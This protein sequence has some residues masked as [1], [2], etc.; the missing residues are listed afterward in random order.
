MN[1]TKTIN[2]LINELPNDN[3]TLYQ[4]EN[5]MTH[6][7]IDNEIL[8]GMTTNAYYL[9]KSKRDY[10]G[11]LV[12]KAEDFSKSAYAGSDTHESALQGQLEYIKMQMVAEDTAQEFFNTCKDIYKERTGVT[13][14][15]PKTREQ[16]E[17]EQRAT[18]ATASQVELE[19]LIALRKAV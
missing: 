8:N 7:S 1:L 6:Q 10:V 14:N 5:D 2:A 13:W 15:P 16:K 11:N 18:K 4:K 3:V 12:K 9:H 19:S 17:L